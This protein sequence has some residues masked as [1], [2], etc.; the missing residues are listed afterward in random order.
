MQ[1]QECSKNR[2][3]REVQISIFTGS[4]LLTLE[5]FNSANTLLHV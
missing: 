1:K 5:L 4:Q 2:G 3:F